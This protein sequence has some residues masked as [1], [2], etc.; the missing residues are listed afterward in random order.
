MS[1]GYGGIFNDIKQV[2]AGGLTYDKMVE[3]TKS[4]K[5]Y[6]GGLSNAYPMGWREYSRRHFRANKDGSFSIYYKN[7]ESVDVVESGNFKEGWDRES[8][9]RWVD[10]QHLATVYPDNTFEIRQHLGQGDSTYMTEA[11]GYWFQSCGARGGTIA[12]TKAGHMH[13]IFKGM[14]L[15]LDPAKKAL[16]ETVTPYTTFQRRVNRKL[17]NEAIAKYDQ[18]L[19]VAPVMV[20][21][22]SK[23]GLLE[24]MRDLV[25]EGLF[26]KKEPNESSMSH[27]DK[28]VQSHRLVDAACLF[29][30]ANNIHHIVYS[31]FHETRPSLGGYWGGNDSPE[32]EASFFK[33]RLEQAFK[34]VFKPS[35]IKANNAFNLKELKAGTIL[36]KS[37]WGYIIE[38]D[39]APV[40]R[41]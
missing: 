37:K 35:I 15:H 33:M 19:N 26:N 16:G 8:L 17:A 23:D 32:R 24:T 6:R 9:T 18:F 39:G 27:F 34:D 31:A 14:R 10:R 13:P 25:D 22:M 3:R 5:P 36:P 40:I 41:V 1:Y 29:M 12:W 11:F 2:W 30:L 20:G 4:I 28:L 21:A 7:R 38:S